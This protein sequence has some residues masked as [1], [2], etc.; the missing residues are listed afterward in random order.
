MQ[1]S[2]DTSRRGP[3]GILSGFRVNPGPVAVSFPRT[4]RRSHPRRRLL[5]ERLEDR[6]LLSTYT[7]NSTLDDGA[8]GTLRWAITQANTVT[9]GVP[10]TIDFNLPSSSTINLE[11]A[12]PNLSATNITIDG[13]GASSLIVERDP[14]LP[15]KTEFS[16]FTVNNG[17][18]VSISGL[19]RQ[20]AFGYT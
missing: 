20:F 15:G 18:T 4:T 1:C 6:T 13:P 14:T 11:S 7:V 5:L 9:P 19:D 2:T 10:N 12:L 8:A 17:A 3:Q 16:V